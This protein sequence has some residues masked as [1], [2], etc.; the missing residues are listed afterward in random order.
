MI[1]A[2][3][4]EALKKILRNG[5]V[6]SAH[7]KLAL[8]RELHAST[9]AGFEELVAHYPQYRKF[10]RFLHDAT[11]LLELVL[12]N[13]PGDIV[14]G[15]RG[16]KLAPSISNLAVAPKSIN[17]RVPS[18]V[19]LSF[20]NL[21]LDRR[22]FVHRQTGM[23]EHGLATNPAG[24]EAIG[25]LESDPHYV[26]I[27]PIPSAVQSLWR[28]EFL[29]DTAIEPGALEVL[30]KVVV[31]PPAA[32]PPQV[33]HAVLGPYAAQWR[34]YRSARTVTHIREWAAE[35]EVPVHLLLPNTP[36]APPAPAQLEPPSASA[37]TGSAPSLLKS[38]ILRLI[39]SMTDDDLRQIVLPLHIAAKLAAH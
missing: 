16:A 20:V 23:I 27:K 29:K 5:P 26:E 36:H 4:S 25:R 18:H 13:G 33:W 24:Q 3:V 35:H 10:S 19:W 22:R 38:E 15:L 31:L 21:D 11:D 8:D 1:P 9:N 37:G 7:L 39:D 28:V 34:L 17:N 14:V 32:Q 6:T 2:A 30:S 12:P